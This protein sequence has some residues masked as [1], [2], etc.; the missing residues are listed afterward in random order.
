METMRSNCIQMYGVAQWVMISVVSLFIVVV[1]VFVVDVGQE[2]AIRRIF[3]P[4][5]RHTQVNTVFAV[6]QLASSYGTESSRAV[7]SRAQSRTEARSIAHL[8]N[9][10]WMTIVH[11][12]NNYTL[13]PANLFFFL[14]IFFS[15]FYCLLCVML[16]I[17]WIKA[18]Y[19]WFINCHPM[20]MNLCLW[21]M[22]NVASQSSQNNKKMLF[23]FVRFKRWILLKLP[24]PFEHLTFLSCLISLKIQFCVCKRHAHTHTAQISR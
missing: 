9:N 11:T 23:F 12:M 22:G 3:H 16:L 17:S 10:L 18:R 6:V 15:F 14:F 4:I 2:W 13:C 21:H 1:V 20:K 24:S 5:H 19:R 7:W 8:A